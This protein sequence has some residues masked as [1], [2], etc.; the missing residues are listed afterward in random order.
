MRLNLYAGRFIHGSQS[1]S[2]AK[3]QL[4]RNEMLYITRTLIKINNNYRIQYSSSTGKVRN[5]S[6]VGRS[7]RTGDADIQTTLVSYKAKEELC[8]AA[9]IAH[10]HSLGLL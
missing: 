3:K 7:T 2:L 8:S 10:I 4:V 9:Y 5:V 6:V 1:Y